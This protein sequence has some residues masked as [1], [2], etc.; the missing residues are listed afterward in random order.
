[1]GGNEV[2][3]F[4]EIIDLKKFLADGLISP[5]RAKDS[6][7]TKELIAMI[8]GSSVEE[9]PILFIAKLK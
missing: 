2:A 6:S 8:R 7:K 5:N 1:M 3:C 4:Y 9:N